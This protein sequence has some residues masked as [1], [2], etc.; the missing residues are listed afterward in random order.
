MI[1][2]IKR[3]ELNNLILFIHGFTGN[4]DTWKNENNISF[5]EMLLEN[6][7]IK[8]NF[9]FAYFTYYTRLFES[10]EA[11]IGKNLL[12]KL[13]GKKMKKIE[14]N[15]D[16]KSIAQY[17]GSVIR[18]NCE[19]YNN[20]ILVAH[21]MGGLISKSYIL[22]ELSQFDSTN[23]KLFIS[24]AVPHDGSNLANL[25]RILI[26]NNVQI[27]GLEPLN[28]TIKELNTKWINQ[29]K[30]PKT[31]YFLGEYDDVVPK[32]SSVSYEKGNPD[33]VYC[34]EDHISISKP[35]NKN[36]LVFKAV[37]HLLE[38]HLENIEVE[39]NTKITKFN[40]DGSYD[41]ELFVLKLILSD[42]H[43]I[44][45]DN[46]KQTFYNA[47]FMSRYLSF[48]ELEKLDELYIKLKL[49]YSEYFS[50]FLS[51]EIKDSNE[52]VVKLHRAIRKED[53]DF[54]KCLLPK[55]N[56]LHKTGMLHQL[57]NNINEKIWWSK[58]I[59][60]EDIDKYR[61]KC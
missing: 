56:E 6:E 3:D 11:K 43:E 30:L 59:S 14:K 15:I 20:I 38:K 46:A 47:E 57:S 16:I 58:N 12:G 55:I 34:M 8:E 4:E 60:M 45:I 2:F 29:N 18:Y 35:N 49:I 17:V 61:R 32:T 33:V 25:G 48:D 50:Q 9:D 21:S 51:G 52:L 41:D 24:L 13:F 28:N 19:E 37:E 39:D 53:K 27:E 26:R 54:L 7:K 44:V 10:I 31:I 5:P 22:D 36:D 23:V 1:E 40:D 42:V